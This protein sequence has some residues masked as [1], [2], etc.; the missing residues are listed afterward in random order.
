MHKAG[1][2][3][4]PFRYDLRWW[5]GQLNDSK[6][7]L[8]KMAHLVLSPGQAASLKNQKSHF[9]T[10]NRHRFDIKTYLEKLKEEYK[11]ADGIKRIET[12]KGT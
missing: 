10:P 11:I 12:N 3:S 9:L 4:N 7:Q 6:C 8:H 5:G 1:F 2:D